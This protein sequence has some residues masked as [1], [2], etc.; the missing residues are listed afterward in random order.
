MSIKE[1]RNL[2]LYRGYENKIKE[3]GSNCPIDEY[4]IRYKHGNQL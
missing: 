4:A 2:S 3:L 1:E